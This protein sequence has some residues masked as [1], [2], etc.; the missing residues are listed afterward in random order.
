[1]MVTVMINSINVKP[2]FSPT[3][4]LLTPASLESSWYCD[5]NLRSSSYLHGLQRIAHPE[6]LNPQ[7]GFAAEATALQNKRR[8]SAG[9]GDWPSTGRPFQRY[10]DSAAF[11]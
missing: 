3:V 7:H 11:R 1:M 5:G 10:A 4:V 9:S 2:F 6:L 8:Q